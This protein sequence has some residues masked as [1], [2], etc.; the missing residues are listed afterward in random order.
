LRPM[1][2]VR[3]WTARYPLLVVLRKLY[4]LYMGRIHRPV[5]ESKV[6]RVSASMR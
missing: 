5:A 6:E 2:R 3:C 1:G 4:I